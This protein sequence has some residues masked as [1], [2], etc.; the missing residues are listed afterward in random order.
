MLHFAH[1]CCYFA[2]PDTSDGRNFR[3]NL[4][5]TVPRDC[6]PDAIVIYKA[7]NIRQT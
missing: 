7:R 5:D 4:P 3:E 2:A 1:N 6:P